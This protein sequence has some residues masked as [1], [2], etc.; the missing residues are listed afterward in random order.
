MKSIGSLTKHLPTDGRSSPSTSPEP[1]AARVWQRLTEI[2]GDRFLREFGPVPN[3]TWARTIARLTDREI[4][5][6]LANLADD[7]L[8]HPPTLGVFVS[9][10]KRLP[11]V[12]HLGVPVAMLERKTASPESKADAIAQMRRKLRC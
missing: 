11:P 2:H 4:M 3:E 10:C 9:A 1:R 7:A 12:R 6:G 5:R 8:A